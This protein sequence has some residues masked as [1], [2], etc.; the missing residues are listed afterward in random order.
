MFWWLWLHRAP[1]DTAT[2]STQ[3]RSERGASLCT[4]EEFRSRGAMLRARLGSRLRRVGHPSASIPAPTAFLSYTDARHSPYEIGWPARV[5]R[6]VEG[7][8]SDGHERV[9]RP[10]ASFGFDAPWRFG[11]RV[12]DHRGNDRDASDAESHRS[13]LEPT[14]RPDLPDR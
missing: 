1:L 11:G 12:F 5:S 2:A 8:F 3:G 10:Q 14:G 9:G 13:G 7:E 4:A 6:R